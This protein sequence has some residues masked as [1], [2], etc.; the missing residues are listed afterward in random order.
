MTSSCSSSAG[1]AGSTRTPTSTTSSASTGS[2]N[3]AGYSNPEL[4]TLLTDAR[5]STDKAERIKLYGDVVTKLQQDDPLIYL[6]RQRN[7]TGVSQKILG[8]AGLPGRRP[9]RSLRRVRRSRE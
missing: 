6:Y 1:P 8:R 2:Q 7:L 4:D 5:Q 3:V 9:A